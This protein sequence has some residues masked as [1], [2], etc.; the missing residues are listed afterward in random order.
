MKVHIMWSPVGQYK[1]FSHYSGGIENHCIDL[2][3]GFT[4]SDLFSRAHTDYDIENK[5]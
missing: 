3:R 2:N 5:L 1:K 4:I